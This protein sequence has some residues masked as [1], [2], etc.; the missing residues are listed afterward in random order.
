MAGF[1]IL[2]VFT[3]KMSNT[4][5]FK[6]TNPVYR[7]YISWDSQSRTNTLLL[8]SI[9]M[10]DSIFIAFDKSSRSMQQFPLQKGDAW[11]LSNIMRSFEYEY[12]D[13]SQCHHQNK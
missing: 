10:K 4:L 8:H 7:Q 2:V 3:I 13:C 11:Y 5:I 1:V 9:E 12:Q 6:S